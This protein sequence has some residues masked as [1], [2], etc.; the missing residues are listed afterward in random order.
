[1]VGMEEALWEMHVRVKKEFS[2][3]LIYEWQWEE[4]EITQ[5]KYIRMIWL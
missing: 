3:N 4:G 2:A 5:K 1:M